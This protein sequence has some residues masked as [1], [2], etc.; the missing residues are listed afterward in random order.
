MVSRRVENRPREGRKSSPGGGKWPSGGF[1]EAFG[2]HVGEKWAP[3][4]RGEKNERSWGLWGPSWG[5]P[6]V[7]LAPLGPLWGRPGVAPGGHFWLFFAPPGS[8]WKVVP[9]TRP[10]MPNIIK[11]TEIPENVLDDLCQ[12]ILAPLLSRRR[13]PEA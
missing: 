3:G 13:L 11:Q 12:H 5:A 9:K 7:L 8:F 1:R 4:A 10:E 2:G 6:G